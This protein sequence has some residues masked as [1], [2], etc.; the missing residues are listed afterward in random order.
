MSM[1]ITGIG[2][3]VTN[4]ETVD[5]AVDDPLHAGLGVIRDAAVVLSGGGED[6]APTVE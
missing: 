2:E 1:L 3:L 4:D 5:G 6:S